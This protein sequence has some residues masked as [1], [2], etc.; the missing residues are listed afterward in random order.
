MMN[1]SALAKDITTTNENKENEEE[2]HDSETESTVLDILKQV[3]SSLDTLQARDE[4]RASELRSIRRIVDERGKEVD[5]LRGMFAGIRV[6][7]EGLLNR[8]VRMKLTLET[9]LLKGAT[10]A[11]T[12]LLLEIPAR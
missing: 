4:E 9:Y 7:M 11:V 8:L 2:R 5:L 12:A 3:K 6:E 10:T 1:K